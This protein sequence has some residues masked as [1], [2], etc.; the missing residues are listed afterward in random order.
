M[1]TTNFD[2]KPRCACLRTRIASMISALLQ[3]KVSSKSFSVRPRDPGRDCSWHTMAMVLVALSCFSGIGTQAKALSLQAGDVVVSDYTSGAIFRVNP[4]TGIQ[5]MISSGGGLVNPHG[6]AI[7]SSGSILV[8]ERSSQTILRINPVTGSQTTVSTGGSFVSIV[9][10]ELEASGQ[11]LVSDVGSQA[12]FRVDPVT[13]VQSTVSSGVNLDNLLRGI[14]VESNGDILAVNNN[15]VRIDPVS[16][17]QTVIASGSN[18]QASANITVKAS[19]NI[20]VADREAF[21]PLGG[22]IRVDGVTS[23]QTAVSS[24]GNFVDPYGIAVETNGQ[25]LVSDYTTDSIY[26]VDPVSGVQSLVSSGGFLA[27]PYDIEIS[28]VTVVPEPSTFILAALGLLSL[29]MTRRR[30]RR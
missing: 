25:I 14:A 2:N 9:D 29:G 24:G 22:V 7:E 8:A 28:H 4:V 21:T 19:G 6:I 11:I 13:G 27:D 1:P 30:R 5:T 3:R 12:I 20:L 23:T 10:L 16:G 18:F 26:R 17:L 15:V